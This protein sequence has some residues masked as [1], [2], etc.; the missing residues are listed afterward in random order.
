MKIPLFNN[1]IPKPKPQQQNN[2]AFEYA[3]CNSLKFDHDSSLFTVGIMGEFKRGKSTVINAL[4]GKNILPAD[5]APTTATPIFIRYGE[6]ERAVLH[7]KNGDEKEI[8]INELKTYT[9]FSDDGF[10]TCPEAAVLYTPCSLLLNSIQLIDTPGTNN[11]YETDRIVRKT[12]LVTNAVIMVIIPGSPFSQSE[13]EF[14]RSMIMSDN[15]KQIVFIV[16]KI[17]LLEDNIINELLASIRQKIQTL[18]FDIIIEKYGI[19]SKQYSD[20]KEKLGEIV[21]LPISAKKAL[22]G[23]LNNDEKLIEESRYREFEKALSTLI[24]E[25]KVKQR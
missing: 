8:G 15:T 17:D 24:A 25:V 14:V 4:L 19:N 11:D 9:S 22:N 13:A 18:V 6:K 16:N 7:F 12:G 21:I 20:A 3:E 5:I 2:N 23:K 10:E 1:I